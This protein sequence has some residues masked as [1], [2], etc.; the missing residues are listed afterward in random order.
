M[1][2]IENLKK[3]ICNLVFV[4][5]TSYLAAAGCS[6]PN[7][8]DL[9]F[10]TKQNDLNDV[11]SAISQYINDYNRPPP[12]KNSDLVKILSGEND[13]RQIYTEFDKKRLKNGQWV[14][15]WGNPFIYNGGLEWRL[16]SK[17]PNGIDEN[18][19]GDDIHVKYP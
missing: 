2:L 4:L 9:I 19:K 12:G 15:V 18:G 11:Q 3:S 16:Y 14:D 6:K 1:N 7:N 8:D 17:G 10:R 13:R 5:S